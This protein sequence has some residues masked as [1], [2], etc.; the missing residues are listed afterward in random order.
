MKTPVEVQINA[1]DAARQKGNAAGIR[2]E[3]GQLLYHRLHVKSETWQLKQKHE[4]I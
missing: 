2:E 3:E 4:Y 1:A